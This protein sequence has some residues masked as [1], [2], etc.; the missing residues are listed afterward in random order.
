MSIEILKGFLNCF[1]KDEEKI[2]VLDLLVKN[3]F[4]VGYL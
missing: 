1:L 3:Y 2:V 4:S